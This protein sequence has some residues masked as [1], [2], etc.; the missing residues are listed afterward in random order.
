MSHQEN[1]LF[2]NILFI[3][4]FIFREGKGEREGEKHQYVLPL[5]NPPPTPQLGT[6]PA[7]QAHAIDWVGIEGTFLKSLSPHFCLCLIGRDHVPCPHVPFTNQRLTGETWPGLTCPVG[8]V[9]SPETHDCVTPKQEERT[10]G[11]SGGPALGCCR[12]NMEPGD[13]L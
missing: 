8:K 4:L 7:T 13:V 12:S 10:M 6:W 5:L 3:Y 1:F 9:S 11:L 2:F